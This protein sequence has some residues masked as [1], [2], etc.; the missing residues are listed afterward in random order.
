M[1]KF[2]SLAK[3]TPSYAT[4]N[5]QAEMNETVGTPRVQHPAS[6]MQVCLEEDAH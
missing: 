6:Q 2:Y 1:P 4:R 3:K 5:E